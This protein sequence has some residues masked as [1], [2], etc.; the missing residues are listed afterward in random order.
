MRKFIVAGN[1]KMNL[2]L[3]NGIDLAN[4]INDRLEQQP[5]PNHVI[6]CPP[7]IHL[8]ALHAVADPNH[9]AI[10]AQDCSE[11]ASGA[12]T[13]EVAADMVKSTGAQYVIL[14]HSERRQYHG[15]THEQLKCKVEQALANGLEV[16]FCVGEPL[17]VR[18]AEQQNDF[19]AKQLKESL[20]GLDAEAMSHIVIA[21]EPIWAIG[22]GKT[23][24]TEQAQQ[25]HAHIRQLIAGQY[26]DDLA[27]QTT[28]L[29]GG[30]CKPSNA[31][32]L[33]SQPDIDGGLIGGASL[34]ADDFLQIVEAIDKAKQQ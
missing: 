18:E 1:W 21:Y 33:F 29:Y 31:E 14:G 7:F 24:T 9:I 8:V 26:G 13:G 12:Y 28:I 25:M 2:T 32:Q 17:E 27:Q 16:I 22:T 23:A 11:H 30:S 34:K 19:V 10:G 20:F 15:E 5:S 6:L 3:Q 4:E